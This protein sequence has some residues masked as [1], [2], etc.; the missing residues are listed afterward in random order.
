MEKILD[1]V[2]QEYETYKNELNKLENEKKS[3]EQKKREYEYNRKKKVKQNIQV[4][5][6][7]IT[8]LII[9]M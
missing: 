2:K 8:R 9:E 3:L 4:K 7:G 6:Y 5:I 1:G